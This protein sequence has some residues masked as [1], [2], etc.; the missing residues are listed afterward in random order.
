MQQ[1]LE[2]IVIA[3]QSIWANKLRS[4]MTAWFSCRPC[5]L[6]TWSSPRRMRCMQKEQRSMM[7]RLRTVTSELSWLRSL[8]GHF[9]SHQLKNRT[10]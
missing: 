6:S 9:G 7:P 3:L 1:I 10:W 4:F 5:C 8:S 2:S